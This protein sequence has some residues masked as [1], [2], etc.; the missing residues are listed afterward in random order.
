M[1]TLTLIAGDRYFVITRPLASIGV[2][3]RR[4]A[5]MVLMG[6]WLYALAWS[7]PPF[8]GWSECVCVWAVCACV[9]VCGL[10]VRVC[11][12]C[13][14]VCGLCVGVCVCVCV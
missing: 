2:L 13:V 9:S 4:R 8:F 12:G 11:L 14:C 10:C 6:V 5:G 3:S 7:L 1:L